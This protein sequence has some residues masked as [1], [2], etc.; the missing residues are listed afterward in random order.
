MMHVLYAVCWCVFLAAIIITIVLMPSVF[1]CLA[2]T[3]AIVHDRPNSILSV[4]VTLTSAKCF[5]LC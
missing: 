5:V 2:V 1:Y 4:S 3:S